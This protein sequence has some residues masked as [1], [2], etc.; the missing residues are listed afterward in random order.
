MKTWIRRSLIAVIG[1]FGLTAVVAGVTGCGHR[2]RGHHEASAEDIAKWRAKAIDRAG[3]ELS[4]DDTQK[5]RLGVLFDTLAAQRSTLMAG[6]M[7]PKQVMGEL[8]AG[9]SF[10]R[11]KAGSLVEEKTSALRAGSPQVI[12]AM[13]DFYDSLNPEQQAKV[14]EFLAKRGGWGRG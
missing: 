10:D 12:A 2:D 8:I 3:R 4:L 5:Q 11:A 1:V 9:P 14:R 6:T 13:G 7:P